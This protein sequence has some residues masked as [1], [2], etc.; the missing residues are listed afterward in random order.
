MISKFKNSLFTKFVILLVTISFF[1]IGFA[2][3]SNNN[4]EIVAEIGGKIFITKSQLDKEV[5]K[6]IDKYKSLGQVQ[7]DSMIDIIKS[8]TL[9]HMVDLAAIDLF[10]SEELGL[11]IPN[12]YI[13]NRIKLEDAF[14]DEK[15]NFDEV[16]FNKIL[17][18]NDLSKKQFLDLIRKD[19]KLELFL[20]LFENIKENTPDELLFQSYAYRNQTRKANVYIV[21][22]P[23]KSYS[24]DEAEIKL[25]YDE[26]KEEFQYPE[27]RAISYIKVPKNFADLEK[28]EDMLSQGK[29][30]KIIAEEY[31]LEYEKIVVNPNFE[32]ENATK[33]DKKNEEIVVAAF[34]L[35]ANSDSGLVFSEN[36][37]AYYITY[38]EEIIN[39][40]YK[41]IEDV[42]DIIVT[43]LIEES[44]QLFVS[45]EVAKIN[46]NLQSNNKFITD[47]KY[48]IVKNQ[49]FKRSDYE[50]KYKILLMDIFQTENQKF[51]QA[52]LLDDD[53]IILAEIINV[54]NIGHEKWAKLDSSN[55]NNL[56]N[57]LNS[58]IKQN[59]LESVM[60]NLYDSYVK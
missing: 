40:G 35:D 3:Y 11:I 50:H 29:N 37:D 2:S 52:K 9:S 17:A 10:I 7:D 53:K 47:L 43:S 6:T 36:L 57:E 15:K 24:F 32:L 13:H 39:K 56:T 12:E 55:K 31:K 23:K 30:L 34:E 14:L 16:K 46:N 28:L 44:K 19:V 45:N 41:N 58:Q 22:L 51:T 27:Y 5:A 20:N 48:Q 38:V 21:D 42:R 25:Y 49:D 18:I 8:Q 33:I 26:N 59:L 4:P 60:R 54:S 1:I